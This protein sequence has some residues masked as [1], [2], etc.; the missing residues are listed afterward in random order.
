MFVGR[1]LFH[2]GVVSTKTIVH[3]R[4]NNFIQYIL[5]YIFSVTICGA[6]RHGAYGSIMYTICLNHVCIAEQARRA[7]EAAYADEPRDRVRT[8]FDT[9]LCLNSLP[10]VDIVCMLQSTI[11]T[12][13][14][15]VCGCGCVCVCV[16]ECLLSRSNSLLRW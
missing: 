16:L 1:L 14:H 6:T 8:L 12:Y 2:H 7:S 4:L 5:G 10:A 15:T 13:L 11:L 3:D 9:L